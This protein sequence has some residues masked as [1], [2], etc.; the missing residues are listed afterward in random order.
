MKEL[1]IEMTKAAYLTYIKNWPE[2]KS[3]KRPS[4][5]TSTRPEAISVR[6]SISRLLTKVTTAPT[7]NKQSRKKVLRKERI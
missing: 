1:T 4:S 2:K 7:A 5:N 3:L 6:L